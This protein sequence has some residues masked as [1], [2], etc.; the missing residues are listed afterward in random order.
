[1][2]HFSENYVLCG[3]MALILSGIMD[4]RPVSDI[5]FVLN[6]CDF[7]R[8]I[9]GSIMHLQM[10]SYK[11]YFGTHKVEV[12]DNYTSWHGTYRHNGKKFSMNFLVFNDDIQIKRQWLHLPHKDVL[13]QD[14]DTIMQYKEKYNRSKDKIDLENITTKAIEEI[15]LDK[16]DR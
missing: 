4:I 2:Q 9:I 10:D 8:N 12:D 1:M 7:D 5:D 16:E 11:G 3:S 14:I 15:L 13:I 6:E